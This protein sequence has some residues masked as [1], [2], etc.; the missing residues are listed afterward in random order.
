MK[1]IYTALFAIALSIICLSSAAE[2]RTNW[3]IV[4]GSNGFAANAF[5][6][7]Y[8]PNADSPLTD[9]EIDD[10]IRVHNETRR[11]VGLDPLKWNC[12]L[13]DFAQKW[14]NKNT[15]EH[16]PAKDRVNLIAGSEAGENLSQDS[17]TIV[18]IPKLIQGWIDEKQ[19]LQSDRKTCTANPKN[20]PCGHYTQM[21]WRTTTEVGCGITRKS[22]TMGAEYSGKASYLVCIYNPGG[23]VD[24]VAA[25]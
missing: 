23:N 2:A 19:F 9:A 10:A 25:Y 8:C 22:N 21:V 12:A 20:I 15:G 11:E 14:A 1:T 6:N 13:A 4:S 7:K 17:E 5:G 24:G 3:E 18:T 16:S